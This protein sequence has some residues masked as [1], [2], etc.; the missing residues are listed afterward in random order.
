M[1]IAGFNETIELRDVVFAYPDKTILNKI[2]LTIKKGQTIAL[3]GSSGA[4]KSTLADLIP[5]FHD[6]TS[7][8]V[9]IDGI[10]IKKY[11]IKDLRNLMGIVTQEPI[12]FNDT[13]KANISL[14]NEKAT[15]D[16]IMAAATIAN[17]H[18]FIEK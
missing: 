6:A 11:K 3:V 16:E 15:I 12:L 1:Y 7:G 13:I 2:N 18:L 10:N 8:E 14:G 9:L 5:R 4:G 17:A